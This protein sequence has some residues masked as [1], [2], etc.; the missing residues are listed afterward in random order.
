MKLTWLT[1]IHL[2][3]LDQKQ[4][5]NF[6][7]KIVQTHSDA[8]LLTGDIAEAPTIVSIMKEMSDAIKQ[9]IYFV[10][11]NHDYYHAKVEDVRNEM[12]NLTETYNLLHWL[13]ASGPQR[14]DQ[15]TILL[16]QDGWADGRLGDY[17]NSRLTLN[18]TK[19]IIDLLHQAIIGKNQL[20]DKMQQ[21]ADHDA[22]QLE[23]NLKQA[24]QQHPKKI[25]V[26]THIPPFKEVCFHK[27][28]ICD[29]NYLPYFSSKATGDILMK[30][31]QENP[32]IE[33]LTLAGHT[34]SDSTYKALPN[35]VVKVGG[36]EYF[37]PAIQSTNES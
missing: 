25:I 30:I 1:D 33:F 27:G 32:T 8:I 2:N 3:F 36:A 12:K 10:L 34:H 20:L 16:G 6:Y 28:K 7:Q 31:A 35:L 21:L 11:G 18:D 37:Q 14:L 5:N 23:Y 29:D 15:D 4:R 13:P 19:F 22:K 9:P 24:L 26:L 17:Y